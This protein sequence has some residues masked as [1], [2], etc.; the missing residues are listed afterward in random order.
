MVTFLPFRAYNT[1][2]Q[3]IIDTIFCFYRFDSFRANNDLKNTT[4]M[5]AAIRLG[6]IAHL[7]R[8]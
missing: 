5:K 7:R 1:D 8:A 4:L 6:P 3:Q 2:N